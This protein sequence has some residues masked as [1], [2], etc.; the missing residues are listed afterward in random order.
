MIIISTRDF[1]ANQTKFLDMVNKGEDIILK[2][3][4]KGSFK[5]VPISEKDTISK[6]QDLITELKGALQQVKEHLDGK[7][8]L[9]SLDALINEL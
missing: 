9:K 3:R 6:K 8:K 5:L 1:R 2:S 7:R 4:E